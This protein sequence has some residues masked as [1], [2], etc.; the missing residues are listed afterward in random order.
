MK[1]PYSEIL[2]GIADGKTIQWQ[3]QGGVWTD[4][5]STAVLDSIWRCS[6]PPERY[7]I[8][9][10]TIVI[11]GVEC[12]APVE[13]DYSWLRVHTQISQKTITFA[14]PEARDAACNDSGDVHSFDGEWRGR[15]TCPAGQPAPKQEPVAWRYRVNNTHTLYSEVPVPDDA[16]DTGTLVP[17]YAAPPQAQPAKPL[18]KEEV[19]AVGGI[20][21][22]DGNIFFT[23]IEQL[24]AAIKEQP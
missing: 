17:L 18:T 15:C 9:P 7:R 21:H 20:V 13:N 10:A 1:H 8:K 23:N 24:N 16:Y 22:S 6:W 2:I 3:N 12:E 19:R 5:D 14:T 11:N 4:T